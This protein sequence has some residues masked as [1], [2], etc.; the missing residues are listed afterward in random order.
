MKLDQT[1]FKASRLVRS[2]KYELAIR[3]L[4]PEV[5][6][7]YGSFRYYYLLGSACLRAGDFGG[8]L[9]YFRLAH[10]A[11]RR[12]PLAILGLAALY[13]RRH[14]TDRAV[15]FYLD[16]LAIDP[17]N[18]VAK[19]AM[20]LIRKQA[21]TDAFSAWLEAG[22]LPTLYPPIPFPGF[23]GREI[24]T[25]IAALLVVCSI[26]FALLVRFKVIRNPL[27]PR[28]SRQGIS[29][30][31]LTRE[32][33]SAPLETGGSYRYVL[34]RV[35]AL[36]TYERALSMFTNYR[37]EAA[38]VNINRIL[39][40]NAADSLKNR[41]RIIISYMEPPG[42]D[43][44]RRI[45]NVEYNDAIKDIILYRDV[46]VIWRGM[47]TNINTSDSGTTFDFL[48]GYDTRQTLQG[49][50][51]VVFGHAVTIH[52]ERPLEVLGRIVPGESEGR[53]GLAGVAIHQS[54]RLEN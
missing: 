13:L 47:A 9:T 11:K 31:T 46:H 41:A 29:E 32:E 34:T 54:A 44:F 39:E 12:D 35:Q 4:E 1:L 21:G 6:R 48:V 36:D 15:D 28:G 3:T 16:V 43:S 18:R 24:F 49:I 27:N 51:P 17:Q 20:A 22:K 45:D 30:F 5:N 25:G 42:F 7:Y 53:I 14:E 40:S 23:S 52:P 26:A 2:G 8:A 50:V 33:R 10:D 19:K 38:R 37:D